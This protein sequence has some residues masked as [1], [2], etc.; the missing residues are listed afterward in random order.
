[1]PPGAFGNIPSWNVVGQPGQGGAV[2]I[3]VPRAGGRPRGAMAYEGRNVGLSPRRQEGLAGGARQSPG[4]SQ[5][6]R[7]GNPHALRCNRRSH[8]PT[9]DGQEDDRD[10]S[11]D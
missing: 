2:S 9:S 1:M 8:S 4:G 10:L 5:E 6:S 11:S 7:S 3:V